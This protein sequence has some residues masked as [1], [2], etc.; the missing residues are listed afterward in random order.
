MVMEFEMNQNLVAWSCH[1]MCGTTLK[2]YHALVL[3][4]VVLYAVVSHMCELG[5]R[6]VLSSF[7]QVT[8]IMTLIN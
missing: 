3:C 8:L 4:P 2:N 6:V 1:G 5:F 7:D